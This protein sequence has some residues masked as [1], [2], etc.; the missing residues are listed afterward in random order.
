ML[1]DGVLATKPLFAEF[2][3]PDDIDTPLTL[4]LELGGVDIQDPS[5]GLRVKTWVAHAEGNSIWLSAE[6]RPPVEWLARAN[7][8]T[9]VSLAFD[10]N[11]RPTIAFVEDKVSYLYWYDTNIANF[12]VTTYAGASSPRVAMDDKRQLQVG[13]SDIIFAY[14]KDNK[15]YY[16][17]QRDRYTIE[18]LLKEDINARILRI[19]MNEINRLQFKLMPV[20]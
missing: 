12:T 6:D 5:Q 9:E 16:R 3:S 7:E 8:I 13:V 17:Q 1:P 10:Q 15:L 19:G 2:L 18:Y 14:V 11:M 4:D 20:T